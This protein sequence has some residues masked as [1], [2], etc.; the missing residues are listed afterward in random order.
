[1]SSF[2]NRSLFSHSLYCHMFGVLLSVERKGK[3]LNSICLILGAE[4]NSSISLDGCHPQHWVDTQQ[5]IERIT[6]YVASCLIIHYM[7]SI[8][9]HNSSWKKPQFVF[10]SCNYCFTFVESSNLN[11]LAF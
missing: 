2:F 11:T 6:V 9:F 10:L 3:A 8:S 1:M 7:M 5:M 4:N